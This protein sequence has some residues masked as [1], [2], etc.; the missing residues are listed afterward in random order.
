LTGTFHCSQHIRG[1]L[2]IPSIVCFACFQYRTR[3]GFCITATFEDKTV[4]ER[5]IS[6]PIIGIA[7][8][9]YHIIGFKFFDHVGAG[10][11]RAEILISTILGIGTFTTRKLRFLDN[12]C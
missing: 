12:G 11:N 10:T 6:I 4:K 9:G 7:K 8:I 1:N 3:C 5:L 2:E